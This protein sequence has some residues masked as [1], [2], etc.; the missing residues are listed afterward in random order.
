M[1]VFRDQSH[2]NHVRDALWKRSAGGASVMVGAGFSRNAEKARLDAHDVP[3]WRDLAKAM[4]D[5]LYPPGFGESRKSEAAATSGPESWLRLAQEYET[6]FGRGELHGLIGEFVR[7]DDFEPG[8]M[9]SRLLRLPWRDVLTTNWDTLLERTRLSVVERAYSVVRN[10][11]EIPL[12]SKPRIVKLHGSLPAQFPLVITEEDYRTYPVTF[13]PFVNTAQ[14]VMMETVLCLIGFSGDDPNFLHWSGW[15]RDNLGRSA[16]KIYLAGWLDL[17]PHRRRMLED[18]NVVPIDL[19]HHPQSRDWQEPLRHQHA[20]DWLLLALEYGRPYDVSYWPVPSRRQRSQHSILLEPVEK[21][22]FNEPKDEPEIPRNEDESANRLAAVQNLL[23]SWSHNREV[24]PG[25]LT[26]P[27]NKQFRL[28]DGTRKW[29]PLILRSL[30][31]LNPVDRLNAIRELIWRKELLM[32]PISRELEDAAEAVLG[33]IDFQNRAIDGIVD[34]RLDWVIVRET[35]LL[36]ALALVTVARQRFDYGIF[37]E[38]IDS[39]S[40]FRSDNR[41]VVHRIHHECCLWSINSLNYKAVEIQLEGW[42]TEKN[43]DPVWM[44]RKSA[45]LFEVGRYEDADKLSAAAL[46]AIRE[47]PGGDLSIATPSRESWILYLRP[48]IGPGFFGY[49]GF[50]GYETEVRRRWEELT[51]LGCNAPAEKRRYVEAIKGGEKSTKGPPFDF[52]VARNSEIVI[53]T[54]GAEYDQWIAAHRA[55]R[56]VEIVGLPPRIGFINLAS[57]ILGLAADELFRREPELAARVVLR[58]ARDHA[59]DRLNSLLSRARV[60]TISVE[61]ATEL[62]RICV[63][64]V[65][66]TLGRIADPGASERH[67][68]WTGRLGM[69]MEALSRFSV[70]LAPEEAESIFVRALQWY[71][72]REISRHRALGKPV[73]SI[74]T[75]SWEALP[76][77]NQRQCVLGVLSAPIVGM[78]DF[79]A[80][81][82]QYPDPGHLLVDDHTAPD[83]PKDKSLRSEMVSFL[84]HGLGIDGEARKRA[85]VRIS[86]ASFH[87]LLVSTEESTVARALWGDDYAA[88]NDLPAGTGLYDWVLI[89]LPEPEPGISEERFRRK[90]LNTEMSPAGDMPPLDYVLR[91]IGSAISGLKTYER[92]LIFSDRER[93]HLAALV[94]RWAETPVQ[95]LLHVTGVSKFMHQRERVGVEEA[96][97]GLQDVLLEVRLSESIAGILY[98]KVQ[99]LNESGI[100]ALSLAAGLINV[101]PPCRFDDI[102]LSMR[103]GLASDDTVL[104]KNA[105]EGL[106]FWLRVADDS[107]VELRP[108]PIDLIGE[109]G[110]IIAARRKTLLVQALQIAKWVFSKGEAEHKEAIGDLASQGLGYLAQE[111]RYDGSQDPDD[112][113]PVLRWGCTHLALA[114]AQNGFGADPAV[115]DWVESAESDPLPEVRNATPPF[116]ARRGGEPLNGAPAPDRRE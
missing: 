2:M 103:K 102:V 81:D 116:G 72:K 99:D 113:V 43:C 61:L 41:D 73:Q 20:T 111:L 35:W 24:Y 94:A 71:G 68:F 110:V 6:A 70:R 8:E 22:V 5:K 59:D 23:G 16:P 79:S 64:T 91:H 52:S 45:L 42:R 47:N 66:F 93:E 109:I 58:I 115:T 100:P 50:L 49:E 98:Q 37:Q 90:W 51:P 77:Q 30:P 14:Q 75:R 88:H 55:V 1:M 13:A 21:I 63:D 96:I 84:V 7:D 112:D 97:L 105:A 56:L 12:A 32:E 18:L 95:H 25:W 53:S 83:R 40:S 57:D 9:H 19:S 89:L 46:A 67:V 17:P 27:G 74:L 44:M 48:G 3:T 15:V 28:S 80:S 33:D 34:T 107:T 26:L 104:A 86:W 39:L 78:G 85:S 11:D 36:I 4:Y 60:A 29:E 54:Y 38:R 76:R 31:D 10:K 69:A 108:P 114:M 92:P 65:E 101:L 87:N 82:D 106:W 62:S